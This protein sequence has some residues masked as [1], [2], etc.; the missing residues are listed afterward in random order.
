MQI[1]FMSGLDIAI[2]LM[3]LF[4]AFVGLK[5]G[6]VSAFF[7]VLGG[8]LGGWAASRFSLFF[9]G[10]F[11][12]APSMA[13]MISF[14]I[15]A[16]GLMLLGIFISKIL[17][18]F[19]LGLVDKLFGALLGMG[20]GLVMAAALCLPLAMTQRPSLRDIFHRSAFTPYLMRVTQ[21]NM[22]MMPKTMW[23]QV[24]SFI[25]PE[26]IKRMRALLQNPRA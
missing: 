4:G 17:E 9:M 3:A 20:F 14:L 2:I 5:I 10:F 12:D 15:V 24:E 21:K 19:F 11:P 25:E 26:K 13:Y 1:D 16:G 8:F 22:R 7:C 23:H 18:S 6:A